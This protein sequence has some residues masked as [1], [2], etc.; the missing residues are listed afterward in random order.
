MEHPMYMP[1]VT[2]KGEQAL[3]CLPWEMSVPDAERL[4][5]VIDALYIVGRKT[6]MEVVGAVPDPHIRLMQAEAAELH[7]G[8]KPTEKK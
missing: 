8:T 5:M 1:F 7:K 3:L 2:S 4:K 6:K